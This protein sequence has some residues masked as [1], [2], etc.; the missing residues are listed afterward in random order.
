MG[1]F[2][3]NHGTATEPVTIE[4]D[5][6]P[7]TGNESGGAIYSGDG[8]TLTVT[9]STF[10]ANTA[11]TDGGAIDNAAMHCSWWPRWVGRSCPSRTRSSWTTIH[12]QSRTWPCCIPV[13]TSIRLTS[14]GP[15]GFA[16][17]RHAQRGETL[18]IEGLPGVELRV[19]ELLGLA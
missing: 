13:P 16:D 5:G 12:C 2:T 18:V 14:P 4:P 1:N 17:V 11:T 9:H 19:D 10:S 6:S 15:E 8:G 7:Q 3:L